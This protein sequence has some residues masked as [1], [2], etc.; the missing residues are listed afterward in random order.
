MQ[1]ACVPELEHMKTWHPDPDIRGVGG[2]GQSEKN[3]SALQASV[4]SKNKPGRG[5][6]GG[7]LHWSRHCL[8][9]FSC[10]RK[11]KPE[12]KHIQFS[13]RLDA[14]DIRWYFVAFAHFQFVLVNK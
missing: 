11:A 8:R 4:W 9:T 5:G 2:G 3:F 6:G 1:Q 13:W 10:G 7:G 14:I 12:T